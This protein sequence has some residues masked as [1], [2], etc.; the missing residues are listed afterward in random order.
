M[1]FITVQCCN[2]EASI[3]ECGVNGQT[4]KKEI[5]AAGW[6]LLG[7]RSGICPECKEKQ[8]FENDWNEAFPEEDD[9]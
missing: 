6:T 9:L 8:E 5:R 4:A 1:V 7:P 2:C 3:T